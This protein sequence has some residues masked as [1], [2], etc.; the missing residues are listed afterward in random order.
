MRGSSAATR[1]F[2][3]TFLRHVGI[4][5]VLLTAVA[6]IAAL[7][8]TRVGRDQVLRQPVASG[9]VLARIVVAPLVSP[10]VYA[11]DVQALTALNHRIV[12]RKTGST[13]ERVKV[14]SETGVILYSDD[15]R[16]IGE[17]YP[18]GPARNRVLTS[19]GVESAVTDLSGPENVLDRLFGRSLDV[20]AG[21]R[22]TSGRPILVETYFSADRLDADQAALTRRIM[23]A[24]LVPLVVLGLLLLPLA[25]SL[26]RR[27]SQVS[28]IDRTRSAGPGTPDDTC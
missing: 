14:W 1:P 17:R 9:D 10:G 11:G 20:Y 16:A 5:A 15:P 21:A 24:V 22:D 23:A 8:S 28:A 6:S 26:A 13:I 2:A 7:T 3:R 27:V 25:Y 18:L 4:G 12:A 19:Q